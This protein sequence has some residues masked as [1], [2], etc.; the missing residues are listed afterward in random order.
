M[1]VVRCRSGLSIIGF[2]GVNLAHEVIEPLSD[3]RQKP[4]A[5]HL[6]VM[7]HD[8]GLINLREQQ[9]VFDLPGE[10]RTVLLQKTAFA[11][12]GLDD[13]LAFQFGVSL[14]DGVAVD[15]QFLGERADGRQRVAGPQRPDAAA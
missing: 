3:R 9:L 6:Q 5:I 15:A 14:G 4:F 12:D 1:L 13:A 8:H 7:R 2:F 11:G 10:R